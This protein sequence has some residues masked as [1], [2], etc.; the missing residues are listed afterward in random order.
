MIRGNA[1]KETDEAE[2]NKLFLIDLRF[3]NV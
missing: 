2:V 1:I 3:L